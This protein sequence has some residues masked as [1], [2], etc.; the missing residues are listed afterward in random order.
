M[1]ETHA[2]AEAQQD[3]N[4]KLKEA[5]GI[6]KYF[7]EGSSLDPHRLAKEEAARAADRES[8]QK[9]ATAEG[10][11]KYGWV[12]TPSP[13]PERSPRRSRDRKDKKKKKRSRDR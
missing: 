6:S 11:K 2:I 10:D 7:V 5:F 8:R 4:N 13:S 1:R 12:H 9:T 3:K